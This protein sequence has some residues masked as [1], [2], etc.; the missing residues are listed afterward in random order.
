MALRLGAVVVML[1]WLRNGGAGGPLL[2]EPSL[3]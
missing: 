3:G 2:I 1:W